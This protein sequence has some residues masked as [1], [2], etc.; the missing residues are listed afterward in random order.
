M[1]LAREEGILCVSDWKVQENVISSKLFRPSLCQVAMESVLT[2]SV[3]YH[4][5]Y[6]CH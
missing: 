6:M 3:V 1:A 5:L 4:Q 2:A